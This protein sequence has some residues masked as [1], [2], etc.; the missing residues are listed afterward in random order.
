VIGGGVASILS[1]GALA[2]A[3][4]KPFCL[5]MVGTGLTTAFSLHL[6]A[7]LP[8]A[9]WP[10]VNCLNIY[11][12]DLLSEPLTIRGG[13]AHVPEAPGLGV[14]IDEAALSRWRME[15][16]YEL[17]K[18]RLLISVSWPSGHTRHYADI[19]QCR[20]DALAGNIPVQEAGVTSQIRPDDGS[21]TWAELFARAQSGP[22]ID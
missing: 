5:Q 20:E 21:Q 1:Q 2:A 19:R 22:V 3:F 13:Y 15:P 8:L 11:A 10:Y 9:R 4:N 17:P 16:P 12:D 7:V 14:G 18:P 6:G